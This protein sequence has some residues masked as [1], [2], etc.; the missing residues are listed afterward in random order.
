MKKIFVSLSLIA[1]TVAAFLWQKN[2]LHSVYAQSSASPSTSMLYTYFSGSDSGYA[3]LIEIENNS[4]DP[5]GNA[6]SAVTCYAQSPG[7]T[8]APNGI[9]SL[10]TFPAGTVTVLSEASITAATGVSLANSGQRAYVI[11]TCNGNFIHGTSLL[12]N[13]SGTISYIPAQILPTNRAF[14]TGPEQLLQ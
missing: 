6:G 11:V 14:T 5:Y 13:P 10:G 1:I 7:L 4:M 2:R 3:T 12:L 9:G 8:G